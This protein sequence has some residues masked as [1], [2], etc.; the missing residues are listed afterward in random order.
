MSTQ[1]H[2]SNADNRPQVLV[3]DDIE[4]NRQAMR[5]VL[6]KLEIDIVEA[7]SGEQGLLQAL[8][9]RNLALV[10]LDIQMPSMGGYEV[11]EFM[12]QDE[13]LRHVPIIFLTAFNQSEANILQGYKVGAVD[14]I[15]KP[16]VTEVLL[17]KVKIF[18]ELW[19]LKSSAVRELMERKA[20]QKR[21]EYLAEYDELTGLVNRSY[22]FSYLDREINRAKRYSTKLAV[23]YM[24]L[25]NFKS[26][27]D[28][29][30][31]QAG[32]RLLAE[33]SKRFKGLCRSTDIISRLGGDE[34][35]YVFT[36][37]T[38]EKAIEAKGQQV[39]EQC[40]INVE[41]SCGESV[42]V[43]PSIGI[44]FYPRDGED[45]TQLLASAD[46]AMFC[47]KRTKEQVVVHGAPT[48]GEEVKC[49]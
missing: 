32:D 10:L 12:Q 2:S 28:R 14:Y 9:R 49:A 30:G 38:D 5:R 44:S 41:L 8:C 11:A 13:R 47:A 43:A 15:Q 35:V 25:D 36:D 24:D 4:A 31:H 45:A 27:N 39:I 34:F 7:D 33:M 42:T 37:V 6:K 17:S 22:L 16:I 19:Q 21:L 3:I 40:S 29:L 18:S 1:S 46:Q 48:H 26:V 20:I 23:M